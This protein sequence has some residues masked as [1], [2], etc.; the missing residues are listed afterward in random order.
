MSQKLFVGGISWDT[1]EDGLRDA[2]SKFGELQEVKIIK[3]RDTGRSRGFGFITYSQSEDASAAIADMDGT[4]LD[5]RTIKVNEARD[6]NDRGR[7]QG[8]GGYG[9]QRNRW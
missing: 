4:E 1:T 3:D 5:G 6:R 2:F 8:G 9:N 7:N